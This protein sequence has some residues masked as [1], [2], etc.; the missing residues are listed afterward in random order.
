MASAAVLSAVLLLAVSWLAEASHF[1]YMTTNWVRTAAS[2][3][4]VTFNIEQAWRASY[5]WG[6]SV[7]LGS[8]IDVSAAGSGRFNF[9]DGSA[10]AA[11]VVSP[12]E[13]NNAAGQDWFI[14][15]GTL[16]RQYATTSTRAPQPAAIDLGNGTIARG[17][18]F[19]WADI[20]IADEQ[21]VVAMPADVPVDV[22]AIIGCAVMTGAGAVCYTAGVQ[23]GQSVAVFG[24][25]GVGLSAIAAA[26]VIGANPI[27]AVDLDDAKLDFARKFG[28]THGVNARDTDAVAEIGKL[29]LDEVES[30]L[31]GRPIQGVDF[32][33]DWIGVPKTMEQI[34]GAARS[35]STAKFPGG[36]AVLVGVPQTDV[37]LSARDILTNEKRYIGSLAG[38]CN[39]ER[40][41]PMFLRWYREGDLDLDAL[42]TQRYRLDQIN[43]ATTALERGQISGRAIMEF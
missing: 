39:P 29:T 8:P 38:S 34:L 20:T 5:P 43:E 10:T 33:F 4:F 36:T 18:V 2:P 1:R 6:V 32:A 23:K 11:V 14:G 9:G 24:V 3:Y 37:T 16:T 30:N 42:V 17:N 15:T 41:F 22:T 19:T 35:G 7:S 27:I 13:I 31:A 40:D 26:A 21:Y 12:K 28:A 25:G